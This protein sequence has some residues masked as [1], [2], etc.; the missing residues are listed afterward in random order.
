MAKNL[1]EYGVTV[2]VGVP[3][4]VENL[5]NKIMKQVEKQGMMGKV[6]TGLKLA[7]MLDKIGIH[8]RRRIF[9]EIINKLGGHLRL[10]IC[11]AASLSKEVAEGLNNFGI[12]TIQGYGLT[13]T[14]PVLTAE[15]PWNLCAGS[16]GTP[17]KSVRIYIDNP[18]SNGIGEIVAWGPNVM[19]GYLHQQKE[20]DEVLKDGWF[21]TGDLG[22]ID[23]KGN[24][25][26]CG[27]KKNVIVM[28]NGKNIFPEEIE[29]LIEKLPYVTESMIFTRE[30]HNE[31]VLWCKIVYS[32]EYLE[33]H[34]ITEEQLA[35]QV[36]TDLRDINNTLP[37]YK[38]INH[39]I[40]SDTPMVKTTTQKIKRNLAMKEIN[41]S[42]DD[43]K[44]YNTER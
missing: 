28:K 31:L 6:N 42:W 8:Q 44:T 12:S 19:Q 30:K 35:Q 14:S 20:T 10:I 27:R 4:I 5:Y 36:S 16:V 9:A 26:I 2:F 34:G 40:L 3:L 23:A 22:R 24:L 21:F 7:S 17:M 29:S 33:E 38:Y 37:V 25:W 39:F 13:E 18:D 11:G 1:E 15:R 43:I 32:P 41:D